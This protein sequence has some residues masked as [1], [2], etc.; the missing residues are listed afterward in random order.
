MT[1]SPGGATCL[2]AADATSCQFDTLADGWYTFRV[3]AQNPLGSGP[4]SASTDSAPADAA[5]R[6]LRADDLLAIR[7]GDDG[8]S[9]VEMG[10]R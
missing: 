4:P 6:H 7:A 8:S 3:T 10:R 2:A 5:A 9:V 1:A